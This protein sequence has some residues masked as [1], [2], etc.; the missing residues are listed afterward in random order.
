MNKITKEGVMNL[1]II[2]NDCVPKIYKEDISLN[3]NILKNTFWTTNPSTYAVIDPDRTFYGLPSVKISQSGNTSNV[4]RGYTQ[5][6]EGVKSGDVVTASVWLYREVGSAFDSS[7]EMR[8]YQNH[9][10]G[11]ATNWTGFVPSLS[12]WT[13][14][15]W[16]KVEKT[17]TLDL[18]LSAAIFSMN[19]VKNGTYWFAAPK[20]EFGNKST[21][22]MPNETDSI[23]KQLNLENLTYTTPAMANNFIEL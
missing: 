8:I 17:Y 15:E 11:S 12:S 7:F 14:G 1:S 21:P 13:P 6:V 19:V 18:N 23:Y 20:V 4:Y 10:D 2:E 5:T 9:N 3:T 22:W 16:F